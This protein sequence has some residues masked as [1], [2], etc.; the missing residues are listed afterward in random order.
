MLSFYLLSNKNVTH[1]DCFPSS[2]YLFWFDR[3]FA[4]SPCFAMPTCRSFSSEEVGIY[5]CDGGYPLDILSVP[6]TLFTLLQPNFHIHGFSQH[7]LIAAN[8]SFSVRYDTTLSPITSQPCLKAATRLPGLPSPA[9]PY[10][11]VW[12]VTDC[13]SD[14]INMVD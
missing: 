9:R 13:I 6:L 14:L 2:R 10:S 3:E 11:R 7:L 4:V 5:V 12:S 1:D 8:R